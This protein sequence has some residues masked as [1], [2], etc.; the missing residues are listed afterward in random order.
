GNRTDDNATMHQ[1]VDA[2]RSVLAETSPDN[3]AYDWAMTQ[4]NLGSALT[5]LSGKEGATAADLQDGLAALR[6][7]LG[8]F[9]RTK[10]PEEWAT[11][12]YEIGVNLK[13]QGD[14]VTGTDLYD[15]AIAAF[16]AAIAARPADVYPVGWASATASLGA[17]RQAKALRTHDEA[18]N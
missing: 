9:D 6:A 13:A 2:F 1:A 3:D 12:Q 8:R 17:A 11:A 15:E 16:E 7:A 4:Y 14:L 10:Y 5:Q 18:L